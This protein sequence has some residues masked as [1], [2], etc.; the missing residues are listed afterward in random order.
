MSAPQKMRIVHVLPALTKGGGERVAV[1][2]A[3]HASAQGHDVT[4]VL[5]YPVDPSWLQDEV[6]PSVSLRFIRRTRSRI[7]AYF[8]LLPWLARNR[9]W[10]ENQDILH[11]HLTFGGVFGTLV[12]ILRFLGR[13]GPR[14]VETYHAVGTGTPKLVRFIHARLAAGRDA[15]ALMA[16]DNFWNAFLAKHPRL[17]AAVIPNG[18]S[19]D[20]K[21]PSEAQRTHYREKAGIP[22]NARYVVGTVGRLVPERQP[23]DFLAVFAEIDHVLGPDV[24]YLL[25]G[26]GPELEHL[27]ALTVEH[28]LEG[29]VH[30]PGL[31]IHPA[32]PFSILDLYISL[33]VGPITGLAALEA[34]AFGLPI[35]SIQALADYVTGADDWI[36]SSADIAAVGQRAAALLNSEPERRALAN[37]QQRY[38]MAHHAVDGMAAAYQQLYL[39]ALTRPR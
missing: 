25:A 15:F 21:V 11:C 1:S 7:G 38:V 37:N 3:N 18:I 19:F 34:A 9:T 16:E 5:A 8:S 33:N 27:Q 4:I 29:R 30:F 32:L 22:D 28:G 31:V 13:P 23:A 24:H 39:R 2:L 36:W 20:H 17:P 35:L 12:Q 14:T 26:A 6:T 10:L